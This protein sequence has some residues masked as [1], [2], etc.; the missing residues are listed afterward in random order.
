YTDVGDYLTREE[1]LAKVAA[2]GGVAGLEPVIHIV[3]NEHGDWLNQ[4]RDDFNKFIPVASREG[5]TAIFR[6]AS[7]GVATGRDAWAYNA[8]R[9]MLASNVERMIA[10]YNSEVDKVASG[11]SR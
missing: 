4:R 9:Q 7:L 3:P 2:A 6:L 1:K 8:S 10:N 5:K 11:E